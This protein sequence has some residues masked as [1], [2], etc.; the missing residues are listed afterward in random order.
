MAK[1]LYDLG[2]ILIFSAYL[3]K[4]LTNLVKEIWGGAIRQDLKDDDKKK[5]VYEVSSENRIASSELISLI[6]VNPNK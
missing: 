6:F 5:Q 2:N 4:G 1:F 3:V